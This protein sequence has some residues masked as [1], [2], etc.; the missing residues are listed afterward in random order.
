MD[1]GDS[2][3]LAVSFTVMLM[4]VIIA[5]MVGIPSIGA[6][7]GMVSGGVVIKWIEKDYRGK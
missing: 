3:K 5:E 2:H 1:F 6:L 4:V 7:L